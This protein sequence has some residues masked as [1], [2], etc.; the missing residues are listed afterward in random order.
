M[1][2]PEQQAEADRARACRR[3]MALR[4]WFLILAAPL[5]LLLTILAFLQ[6]RWLWNF[7]AG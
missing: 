4:R 2:D 5:V 1:N 3:G 7:F 6:W